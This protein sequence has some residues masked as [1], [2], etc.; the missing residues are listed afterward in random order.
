M[1]KESLK[2]FESVDVDA[3]NADLDDLLN[4]NLTQVP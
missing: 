2:K 1:K 4:D 3:L